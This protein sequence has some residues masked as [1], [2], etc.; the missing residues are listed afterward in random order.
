MRA[1][2]DAGEQVLAVLLREKVLGDEPDYLLPILLYF[3]RNTVAALNR[4]RAAEERK[5]RDAE[6]ER[7]EE[8]EIVKAKIIARIKAEAEK[9]TLDLLMPNG[10]PLRDCTGDDCAHFG[11]WYRRLATRVGPLQTVGGVLSEDDVRGLYTAM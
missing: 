2:P 7:D 3:V 5:N 11:G 8:L 6:R 9:I 4:E 10:K 1:N